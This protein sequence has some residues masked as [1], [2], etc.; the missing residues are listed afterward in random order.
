MCHVANEY[1]KGSTLLMEW[2][3]ST[4]AV[5]TG[6]FT[7]SS[8]QE[9]RDLHK[10]YEE[11]VISGI[12]G[13]Q[14]IEKCRLEALFLQMPECK[15]KEVLTLG[16]MNNRFVCLFVCFAI[17][18]V[19]FHLF[20]FVFR[21]QSLQTAFLRVTYDMRRLEQGVVEAEVQLG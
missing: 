21:W 13:R 1:I 18:F 6:T 3:T 8:I 11:F 14:Q 17:I 20:F 5:L 10:H 2:I 7:F 16:D 4:L 12:M 15:P 9:A 19:A